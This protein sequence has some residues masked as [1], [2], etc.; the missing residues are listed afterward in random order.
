MNDRNSRERAACPDRMTIRRAGTAIARAP[1]G[2]SSGPFWA[3]LLLE[4]AQE[5]EINVVLATLDPGVVTHWH[6]HPRGQ[7]LLVLAGVGRAQAE[8]GP[9]EEVRAGDFVWF[10]PG[11]PHWHG[12]SPDSVFS[13][14]TV[15]AVRD[16]TMVRWLGPVALER[17]LP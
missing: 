17:S 16:G 14:V 15:Q 12:A 3:E 11:E 6:T 10:A 9:A 1:D 2:V 4:S 8:G 13:Y 7:G 5:G